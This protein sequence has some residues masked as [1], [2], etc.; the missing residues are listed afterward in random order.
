MKIPHSLSLLLRTLRR[1]RGLSQRDLAR[2]TGIS[3][4]KL[5]RFEKGERSPGR[6]ELEEL[7]EALDLSFERV[8]RGTL[9]EPPRRGRPARAVEKR[10]ERVFASEEFYAL[11][12]QRDFARRL[13]AC[14]QQFPRR[15]AELEKVIDHRSD[16]GKVQRFLADLPCGS[17]CE[18]LLVLQLVAL[19]A[20]PARLS[21]LRLGFPDPRLRDPVSRA[22]VGHRLFPA[23]VLELKGLLAVFFPQVPVRTERFPCELDFLVAVHD[24]RASV[25]LNLEVDGP[26]HDGSRDL[27]RAEQLGLPTCRLSQAE[28]THPELPRILER[29]LRTLGRSHP[30]CRLTW[31]K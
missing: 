12:G 16:L 30:Y 11:A 6:Q 18:C 23:L 5:C 14:R 21:P 1:E 2:L 25:W 3:A 9:W 28:L 26:G 22:Y 4:A 24:G 29:D 27:P 31:I 15:C 17:G 20:V 19:G 8:V 13:A 10:V 7:C